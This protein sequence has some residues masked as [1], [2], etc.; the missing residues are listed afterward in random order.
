[1]NDREEAQRAR[2]R[3]GGAHDEAGD[4]VTGTASRFILLIPPIGE[5]FRDRSLTVADEGPDAH[6]RVSLVE[7][8]GAA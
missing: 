8:G 3:A 7:F 2:I 5:I 4:G 6:R 1:M